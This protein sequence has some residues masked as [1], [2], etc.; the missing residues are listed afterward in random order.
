MERRDD[1]TERSDL[2]DLRRTLPEDGARVLVDRIWPQEMSKV[3][4][5]LDE[6]SKQVSPSTGLRH[7]YAQ[8]PVHFEFSHRYKSELTE[9]ERAEGLAHLCDL[10]S[11]WT[12]TLLTATKRVEFS[13]VAVLADIVRE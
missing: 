11:E 10:A 2:P 7:W 5:H 12:L 9:P 1:A 3:R 4:A 8:D 6:W 13:E